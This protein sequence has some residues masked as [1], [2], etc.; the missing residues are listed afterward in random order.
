MRAANAG[1]SVLPWASTVRTTS[2]LQTTSVSESP[3]ISAGRTRLI[4]SCE[5][6]CSA[7]SAWNSIPE[8]LMFSV[9][10]N[11][12]LFRRDGDIAKA[13][14]VGI[15]ARAREELPVPA[16]RVELQRLEWTFQPPGELELHRAL[17][18][19]CFSGREG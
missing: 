7:S 4:S 13:S 5:F 11:A 8:R 3:A 2:P 14:G 1:L 9:F 6:G 17:R 12:S 10:P 18:A 15:V 19:L 16:P